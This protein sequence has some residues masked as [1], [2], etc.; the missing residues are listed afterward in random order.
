[1]ENKKKSF[2]LIILVCFF[3]SCTEEQ[4]TK[5]EVLPAIYTHQL[6][7]TEQRKTFELDSITPYLSAYFQTLEEAGK[8]YFLIGNPLKPC[9]DI[10]DLEKAGAKIASIPLEKEGESAI[11]SLT[12]FYA[13]SLDSIYIYCYKAYQIAL[14]NRSGKVLKRYK[15]YEKEPS[16]GADIKTIMKYPVAYAPAASAPSLLQNDT[17]YTGIIDNSSGLFSHQAGYIAKTHYFLALHTKTGEYDLRFKGDDSPYTKAAWVE[18]E[19]ICFNYS[20]DT[21]SILI[22][23]AMDENIYLKGLEK[24]SKSIKKLAKSRDLEQIPN[25]SSEQ[26]YES[27][28]SDIFFESPSYKFIIT[29]PYRKVYYRAVASAI[30]ARN[31]EG[32][33][34]KYVDKPISF[35]ILDENL[36]IIGESEIKPTN[37]FVPYFYFITQE[38]LWLSEGHYRN[39]DLDEDNLSFRLFKLQRKIE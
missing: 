23:Y 26:R 27:R 34:R 4:A 17:L 2:L 13:H 37:R 19:D 24:E 16:L 9:I 1:M 12:G 30:E 29:D 39:P 18:M 35:V 33:M 6:L 14:V 8:N 32:A 15:L 36:N 22:S 25:L 31:Q 38:G 7:A 10:Y 3:F 20:F 11:Y 28:P 5:Q 21:K